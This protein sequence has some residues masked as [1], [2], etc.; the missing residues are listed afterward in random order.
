MLMK[1]TPTLRFVDLDKFKVKRHDGLWE[2]MRKL[3]HYLLLHFYKTLLN[4]TLPNKLR[5]IPF[6]NPK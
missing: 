1:L 6:P 3:W 5:I 2:N 4:L